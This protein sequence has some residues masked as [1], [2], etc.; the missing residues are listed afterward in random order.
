M[1]ILKHSL[2]K[3]KI[4]QLNVLPYL[5]DKNKSPEA[6][7]KFKEINQAYQILSDTSKR[8]VYDLQRKDTVKATQ[9]TKSP[10]KTPEAERTSSF[11]P[12]NTRFYEK[13]KFDTKS[14]PNDEK[15]NA[16][17]KYQPNPND[18]FKNF[19]EKESSTY[20]NDTESEDE[21]D[22]FSELL[23]NRYYNTTE[24][25]Q[26]W[27][28]K[29]S[30][31]ES[32]SFKRA[33]QLNDILEEYYMCQ[34]FRDISMNMFNGSSNDR[35]LFNLTYIIT[36]LNKLMG[37]DVFSTETQFKSSSRTTDFN[38][39]PKASQKQK[40]KTDSW[41][42]DWL[43]KPTTAQRRDLDNSDDSDKTD[44]EENYQKSLFCHYCQRQLSDDDSLMKH[45]AICKKLSHNQNKTSYNTNNKSQFNKIIKCQLCKMDLDSYEYLTHKCTKYMNNEDMKIP[46]GDY[47]YKQNATPNQSTHMPRKQYGHSDLKTNYSFRSDKK[48][49]IHRTNTTIRREK[50]KYDT[51]LR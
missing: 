41:E 26:K 17:P 23:K 50:M 38:R 25:R 11:T 7:C 16:K 51:P 46:N 22:Y 40:S 30:S 27:N 2:N 31:F 19:F 21:N 20:D 36:E 44:T 6:E 10:Q 48:P 45:E 37:R 14:Q 43:G 24:T 35:L 39:M 28:T 9:R 3:F 42:F 4:F 18:S 13:F 33:E 15:S 1:H 49:T 32:D 8:Q 34:M 5:I 12:F 29:W 47:N